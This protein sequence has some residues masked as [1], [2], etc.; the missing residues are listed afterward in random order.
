[1]HPISSFSLSFSYRMDSLGK[2]EEDSFGRILKVQKL[3]L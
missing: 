2:M 1:V 3:F